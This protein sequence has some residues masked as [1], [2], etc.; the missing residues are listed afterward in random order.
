MV[1]V[2]VSSHEEA[3]ASCSLATVRNP[4]IDRAASSPLIKYSCSVHSVQY[5]VAVL[6]HGNN[7][8][9]ALKSTHQRCCLLFNE[10]FLD[11]FRRRFF[12]WRSLNTRRD[13]ASSGRAAPRRG[14]GTV[15]AALAGGAGPVQGL[16]Q[17]AEIERLPLAAYVVDV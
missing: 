15:V 9:R 17:P 7:K 13:P 14:A 3:A 6:R 5:S 11:L 4:L 8:I 10:I 2:S 16:H 1:D 12:D